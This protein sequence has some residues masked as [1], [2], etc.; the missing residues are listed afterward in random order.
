MGMLASISLR[1]VLFRNTLMLTV[2][3]A[4]A[5]VVP[6]VITPYLA[7]VLGVEQYG[8]LGIA[9]NIIANLLTFT[10]WGFSLSAT[11]EV[12]RNAHDPIALR[13][14]FW[15]T[16]AAKGLLGLA[17]LVAVVVIMPGLFIVPVVEAA[18]LVQAEA[19]LC[20]YG[21]SLKRPTAPFSNS[22]LFKYE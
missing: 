14:I 4:S 12:A 17:S 1:N 5:Y 13:E 20:R 10:D 2:S 21:G 22:R 6:L 8:L 18:L 11:R 7:R 19:L 9:S 15:D 3:Q 16:M